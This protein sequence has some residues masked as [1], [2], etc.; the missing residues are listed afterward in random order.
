MSDKKG[1]LIRRLYI[2]YT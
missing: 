2:H 1:F